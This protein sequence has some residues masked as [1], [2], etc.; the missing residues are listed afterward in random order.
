VVALMALESLKTGR[1]VYFDTQKQEI[2][3]YKV[4]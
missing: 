3:D 4:S 2:V 1:K